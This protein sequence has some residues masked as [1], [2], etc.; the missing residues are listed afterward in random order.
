MTQMVEKRV[1]IEPEHDKRLKRLAGLLGIS[2]EELIREAVGS[3]V[4]GN[5]NDGARERPLDRRAW[6]KELEFMKLRREGRTV[7][8]SYPF[9]LTRT[10]MYDE[11]LKERG[12]SR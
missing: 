8:H 11:I 5:R 2:E 9:R 1:H 4:S 12:T 3:Y 10:E 6:L 7:D